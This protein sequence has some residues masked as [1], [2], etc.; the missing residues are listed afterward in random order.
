MQYIAEQKE[1]VGEQVPKGKVQPWNYVNPRRCLK[2]VT[3]TGMECAKTPRSVHSVH[4]FLLRSA[5]HTNLNIIID[6]GN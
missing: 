1:G 5:P 6:L 2:A 3:R 4:I